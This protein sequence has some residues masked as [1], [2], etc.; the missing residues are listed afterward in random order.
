M[1]RNKKFS[2]GD[3]VRY[4]NDGMRYDDIPNL[5]I[6]VGVETHFYKCHPSKTKVRTMA[7]I[8]IRWCDGGTTNT[9]Q[10][11]LEIVAAA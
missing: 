9:T 3:L 10:S 7:R 2:V 11:L 4:S 8:E 5:A 6:V 1:G